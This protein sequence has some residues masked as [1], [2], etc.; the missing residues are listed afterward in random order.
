MATIV[1]VCPPARAQRADTRQPFVNKIIIEGNRF[2]PTQEL[3]KQMA[4]KESSF[5]SIFK[6]PKLKM[7]YL[8]RDVAGLE[9]LYHASGFLDAR[10][11]VKEIREL[12][13][14]AFVDVVIEVTENE[15][16]RVDDV[17][18]ANTGPLMEKDLLK[19][20][21]LKRGVPYNPSLL[22][23]DVY[24]IKRKYFEKGYLD[25]TVRDS[26]S[27]T[28][29]RV[30]IR[31]AIT[32]GPVISIRR[33]VIRG[34][35]MTRRSIIEKELMFKS[36]DR[37]DLRKMVETQ[38][39]LFET[40][41]FTEAEI[42]PEN[43]SRKERTVDISVRVTERKSAYIEAGFGVGNVLGSRVVAEWGDNNLLGTGRTLRLKTEYSVAVFE[44]GRFDLNNTNVRVKFY[45]YDARFGQRRLF[46]TKVLLGVNAFL[47]RDGTVDDIVIRTRGASIGGSRH[48]SKFTD[49]LLQLS[50]E[51]IKRQSPDVQNENSTSNLI[52]GS[53]SHDTRDFILD[54]HRGG[55]RDMSLQVAGGVL[56]GDND[57][58]TISASVQRYFR[59]TKRAVFA[60]RLRAGFAD[61][62]GASSGRGVP[63]ENRFFAGGGN[64]VRGYDE[65]SLGPA[66]TT[67]NPT[68][69]LPETAVLGGRVLLLTNA[70]LRFPIPLLGRYHFSAAAFLDGGNVWG[71]LESVD[72]Q[73]F[74]PYAN[75][76]EVTPDDY[77]YSV[78]VG[79]RYAT[80]VGPVRLDYGVPIKRQPGVD[81]AR[82]HV[83]LGQM[84]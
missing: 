26:V 40:G 84:F 76:D 20:L 8:R 50:Q 47:E 74:R 17:E 72:F 59:L 39:N 64:S 67:I 71:S 52:A 27:V 80:P 35:E 5:F 54:P 42:I 69:G 46:G 53:I 51:R 37:F 43:L 33:I 57:F 12:E 34:N 2:F 25:V 1:F 30:R 45:R 22:S 9:A 3:K 41:L 14:K 70:E 60:V 75:A 38:R 68:T 28:D 61:A 24:S 6:K 36:G 15:A 48:L 83:S 13:N 29:R 32:P 18:L 16:T 58:Y 11:R 21:L 44:E 73:D 56:G 4:T 65:N 55:Y 79:L 19:K 23:T 82:F 62:F 77:R 7:D 81:N 49:A 66:T 63:V 31:Y 78:G 10:V